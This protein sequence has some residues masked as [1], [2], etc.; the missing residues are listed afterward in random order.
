MPCAASGCDRGLACVIGQ[1]TQGS[2][3]KAEVTLRMPRNGLGKSARTSGGRGRRR[4]RPSLL[5]FTAGGM[6]SSVQLMSPGLA[7]RSTW[8]EGRER[9]PP[10]TT[11][12]SSRVWAHAWGQTLRNALKRRGKSLAGRPN[13]KLDRTELGAD[14]ESEPPAS[15]STLLW[16]QPGPHGSRPHDSPITWRTAPV[17]RIPIQAGALSSRFGVLC[18]LGSPDLA[19]LATNALFSVL[20]FLVYGI[21]HTMIERWTCT[22]PYGQ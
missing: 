11:S 1:V 3:A 20:L 12:S 5:Y 19:S 14:C 2:Q 17:E 16:S 10:E 15:T 18:S 7:A 13:L 9:L 22:R 6:P 4:A 21:K 8:E